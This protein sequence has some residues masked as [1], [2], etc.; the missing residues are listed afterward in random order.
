MGVPEVART[1]ESKVVMVQH[2]S[3]QNIRAVQRMGKNN[4]GPS[5]IFELGKKSDLQIW[6]DP[7]KS[8][9]LDFTSVPIN[10]FRRRFATVF[11][12]PLF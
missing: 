3:E 7:F 8:G 10:K 5:A 1:L 9:E 11:G 4:V 6:Q 2:H 12:N